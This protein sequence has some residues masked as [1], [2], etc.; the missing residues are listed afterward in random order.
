MRVD[1]AVNRCKFDRELARL[2]DR[3]DVLDTRGIFLLS[4]SSFPTID[5]IF[6]PRHLLRAVIPITQQGALFLPPGARAAIEVPSLSASAFK[7]HFDLSNYDLDPP[8]LEFRDPWT[9]API[10]YNTMFRAFQFDRE[11]KGHVVLLDD[12]PTTHKPFLCVR[13]IRE[14][15]H[16]PQHSGDDW[17]LYRESMN[18]FSILMSLWRVAIDLVHPILLIQ[19]NGVQV[20]WTAEEKL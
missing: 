1:P 9:D 16:H 11:R 3:R 8:S 19:E 7:A 10:P 18:M 5:L 2:Q 4:S 14:Y 6:V 20:Q 17:L 13:G 12:H 15:H